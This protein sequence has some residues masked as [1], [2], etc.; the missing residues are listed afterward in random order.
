MKSFIKTFLMTGIPFGIVMGILGAFQ[1]G[2]YFGIPS[3]IMAGTFFGLAMAAFA[4]YQ[5]NHFRKNPPIFTEGD[6]ILDA[7]ANHFVKGIAFGGWMYLTDKEVRFVG[8]SA[9]LR[10]HEIT[11]P[12]HQVVDVRTA[13]SLGLLTNRL[14]LLL[15]DGTEEKFV[16]ESPKTWAGE[17]LRLRQSYLDQPR[18]DDARLFA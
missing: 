14:N 17:V 2:I 5:A 12:L 3:G 10:S 6:H 7:A 8:H 9:N 15:A 11:I 13:K 18:S 4:K 16:V 1:A